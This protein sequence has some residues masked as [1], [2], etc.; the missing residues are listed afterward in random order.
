MLEIVCPAGQARSS[1]PFS[2][3][4]LQT[5]P[6]TGPA[7]EALFASLSEPPHAAK[8]TRHS[9]NHLDECVIVI[10][11][12]VALNEPAIRFSER[13]VRPKRASLRRRRKLRTDCTKMA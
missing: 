2:F 5:E 8:G 6:T 12:S 1:D 9:N 11:F 7:N 3:A 4:V 13:L 10:S